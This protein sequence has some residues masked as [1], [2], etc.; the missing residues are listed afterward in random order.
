MIEKMCTTYLLINLSK[1]TYSKTLQLADFLVWIDWAW[2]RIVV[3]CEF[4]NSA[5]FGVLLSSMTKK[6]LLV[7]YF[8]SIDQRKKKL[9][10]NRC[11]HKYYYDTPWKKI[12]FCDL[13]PKLFF[14]LLYEHETEKFLVLNFDEEKKVVI[15]FFSCI[16]KE[17]FLL[18]WLNDCIYYIEWMANC[19]PK[20]IQ[21]PKYHQK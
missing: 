16:I 10:C 4:A 12:P 20:K 11:A 7:V 19:F 8:Y 9:L 21:T 6:N 3:F 15:D 5:N 14:C 17:K 13:S 1:T 18:V 2:N